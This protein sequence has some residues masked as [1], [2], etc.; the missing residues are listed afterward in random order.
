MVPFYYVTSRLQV[1]HPFVYLYMY[2]RTFKWRAASVRISRDPSC[3]LAQSPLQS[4]YQETPSQTT[5]TTQ[6]LFLDSNKKEKKKKINL[7]A[8][9]RCFL[10]R[11]S[12]NLT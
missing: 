1:K 3:P 6:T 7:P 10:S 12:T 9:S 5:N 8:R 11:R 2:L 4:R